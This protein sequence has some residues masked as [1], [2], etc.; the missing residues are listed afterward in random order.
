MAAGG[1]TAAVSRA[2][3]AV[4]HTMTITVECDTLDQVDEALAA[5]ADILLLDNMTLDQLREAVRRTSG[6]A[7]TEASGGVNVA[8]IADIARTG[9]DIISVG[10]LTHS[11]TA[12]DI[13]LDLE[14]I[15]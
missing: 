3:S 13:G 6:K 15:P 11:A 9:V 5:K 2:R 7:K 4:S 1:I 10:A 14:L 8:T 12:L